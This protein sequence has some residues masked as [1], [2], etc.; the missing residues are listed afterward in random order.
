[1]TA[2]PE[3]KSRKVR[4]NRRWPV[5]V[6]AGLL[7]VGAGLGVAA[8][9]RGQEFTPGEEV[10]EAAAVRDVAVSA[11]D[12]LYPPPDTARFRGRPEAVYVYL[13]VEDLPGPRD[14]PLQARVERSDSGSALE[15]LLGR[16]EAEG[17]SL[18]DSG[19]DRISRDED[20]AATGVVKFVL[21]SSSGGKVPPG[22]YTVSVSG[23]S[24]ADSGSGGS[25]TIVRKAFA[26]E[27]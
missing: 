22:D 23:S 15:R 13:S 6:L 3:T 16:R 7:V 14:A 12:S 19:Q 8:F 20:G 27:G 26:V 21:R 24:E 5:V 17:L 25:R 4:K 10:I 1:L 2:I 9:L 18:A 11:E